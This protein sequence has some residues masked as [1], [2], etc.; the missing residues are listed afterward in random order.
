MGFA[1]DLLE[2]SYHLVHKDV[3]TPMQASLRRAVSTAYYAV[4]FH[5]LVDEA[6]SGWAVE[7]A[8]AANWRERSTT[9]KDEGH[10]RRRPQECEK[11]WQACARTG[12]GCAEDFIR[13]QEQRHKADY[14]NSKNWSRDEA[15]RS[16]WDLRPM[17]LMLGR[18]SARRMRR[19][20]LL[21]RFVPA[22]TGRPLVQFFL[23]LPWRSR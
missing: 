9:W 22:E 18:R 6:V 19:I 4:F 16:S 1:D 14:D 2:Q 15:T 17:L 7:H 12:R 13:L 21:A 11:R 3:G 20:G 5:L 8:S 10:L 23:R